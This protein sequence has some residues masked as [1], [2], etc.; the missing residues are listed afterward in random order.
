MRRAFF[1]IAGLVAFS[2][3]TKSADAADI[4]PEL[5]EAS[6]IAVRTTN[7]W[8][9]YY[10]GIYGGGAW[11]RSSHDFPPSTGDFKISGALIGGTIGYNFQA[12]NMV[13]GIEFDAGWANIK[14]STTTNCPG[15][16]CETHST[17]LITLR[18]RLGYAF[19]RLLPF[20]TAGVA[21][22]EI[23]PEV[24][25]VGAASA[26]NTGVAVG[27]GAEFALTHTWF[28]KAEYLYVRLESYSCGTCALASAASVSFQANI[29]RGGLNYKF[30]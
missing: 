17:G 4:T 12:G 14:G 16:I 26:Y 24:A 27:A 18:G 7:H 13:A 3:V 9:G 2:T 30:D 1:M 6:P 10:F 5:Q 20:V 25:G 19:D 23:N 28:V 22:G 29:L 8:A 21:F 11:G 15:L